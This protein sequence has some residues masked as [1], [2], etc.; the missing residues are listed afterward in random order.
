[1]VLWYVPLAA[2]LDRWEV[3]KSRAARFSLDRRGVKLLFQGF[4]PTT[5]A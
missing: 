3:S 1:M 4:A 5:T 2:D